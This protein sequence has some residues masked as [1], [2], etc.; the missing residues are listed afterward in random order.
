MS[1]EDNK[2]LVR[3]FYEEFN[4]KNLAVIDQFIDP[5]FVD[6][7]PPPGLPADIEGA[8]QQFGI[9]QAFPDL[10][11]TVQ[12]LIAEEDKVMAR[13]NIRGT[14][15]GP[16]MG[17]PPS[18]RHV[19]FAAIDIHRIAGGKSVEHWDTSDTLGLLQQL[20]VVHSMV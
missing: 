20:G 1:T 14:H 13:L 5:N 9:F 4:K 7:S 16:F 12:D 3:R 6:H 11:V 8:K 15:Q 19:T 18:G 10:H 2:A 17:L